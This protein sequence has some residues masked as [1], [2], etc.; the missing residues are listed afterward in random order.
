MHQGCPV[1]AT[2]A[3]GAVAGGLVRHGETGWVVA[4]GDAAA[5]GAGL[6]RLLGDADVRARLG[7]AG[8]AAVAPYTPEA[9][10]DAFSRALAIARARRR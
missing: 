2:T 6:V 3:V 9:M 10:A 1:L 4:P 8:R 5:L 7:A